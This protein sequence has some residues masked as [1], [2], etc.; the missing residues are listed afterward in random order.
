MAK[1]LAAIATGVTAL[2]LLGASAVAVNSI[3]ND[4]R[5]KAWAIDSLPAGYQTA[6]TFTFEGAREVLESGYDPCHWTGPSDLK[7]GVRVGLAEGALTEEV[8]VDLFRE[9]CSASVDTITEYIEQETEKHRDELQASQSVIPRDWS[10]NV[11]GVIDLYETRVGYVKRPEGDSRP[12]IPQTYHE[13]PLVAELADLRGDYSYVR[14]S[15][16]VFDGERGARALTIAQKHGWLADDQVYGDFIKAFGYKVRG[17]ETCANDQ[18]AGG[19][20]QSCVRRVQNWCRS[21]RLEVEHER[22]KMGKPIVDID[23]GTFRYSGDTYTD[24]SSQQKIAEAL[25]QL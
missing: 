18:P 24:I 13:D 21:L 10:T 20:A 4:R 14:N 8:V 1:K 22:V 7:R 19:R 16:T 11:D 9:T 2:T 5:A 3:Q 15:F 17:L 6:D 23:C 25:S 12:V